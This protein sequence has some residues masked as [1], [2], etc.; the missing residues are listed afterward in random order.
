M[1]M[2]PDHSPHHSPSRSGPRTPKM[3]TRQ[4]RTGVPENKNLRLVKRVQR[5][6]SVACLPDPRTDIVKKEQQRRV[7]VLGAANTGK[8]AIITQF[9]YERY[10][11]R[12]K[13]TVDELHR[14]E[15]LIQNQGLVLEILDTSGY[16]EFPAMREL[17]IRKSD[18][19]ILVFSVDNEASLEEM[20][21]IREEILQIKR[22]PDPGPDEEE[23]RPKIPTVV[24]A[25]KA[26]IPVEDWAVSR[27]YVELLVKCDWGSCGYIEASA[28]TNYNIVEIFKELLVQ[29]NIQYALSPAIKRRRESMP[30]VFPPIPRNSLT[31]EQR[32]TD[33]DESLMEHLQLPSGANS[34]QGSISGASSRRGSTLTAPT[35]RDSC[36]IS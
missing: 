30:N 4:S 28:K 9:L 16:F 36:N 31:S 10:P 33:L 8:S 17:A 34:R 32:A 13:K 25:N 27:E 22:G 23:P 6:L 2:F 29:A 15:Y 21:G 5:K 18:A 24:V 11:Y 20:K 3:P 7:T 35:K 12:Y 1:P 19:F 14:A 26:D